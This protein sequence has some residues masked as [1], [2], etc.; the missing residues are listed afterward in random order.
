MKEIL[1][2][3]KRLDE[4]FD[5]DC[6]WSVSFMQDGSGE[7]TCPFFKIPLIDYADTEE[8]KAICKALLKS[9]I[10]TQ[11]TMVDTALEA[12]DAY[13]EHFTE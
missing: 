5:L 11:S 4:A 3:L 8:L 7:L 10:S 9:R 6:G 1:K 2:L 12:R 13:R